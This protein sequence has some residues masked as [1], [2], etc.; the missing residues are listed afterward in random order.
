MKS[1]HAENLMQE[2]EDCSKR[3]GGHN[4]FAGNFQHSTGKAGGT[5]GEGSIAALAIALSPKRG[6]T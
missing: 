6:H 5:K 3:D 1:G 4:S 2:I